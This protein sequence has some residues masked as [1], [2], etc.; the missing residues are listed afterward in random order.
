MNNSLVSVV[1]CTYNGSRFVREQLDSICRQTYTNLEI[2]IMDDASVDGT[3]NIL[4]QIT[5]T[6]K[7][8]KLFRNEQ[9]AGFTENFNRGVSNCNGDYIAFADQDDLWHIEKISRMMRHWPDRSLLIYCNSERFSGIDLPWDVK[10][11]SYY[12]RFEGTDA[13]KLA[14]FNTISGHALIIKKELVPLVFPVTKRV[15]YDWYAGVVAACNGGVSF[16]SDTLVLQRVHLDNST[17]DAGFE[18]RENNDNIVFKKMVEYQLGQFVHSP[19]M[20]EDQII[21]I[22]RLSVK[23]SASLAQRF[24]WPLFFFLVSHRRI[25]FWKKRKNWPFLTLV[26]YC[27]RLTKNKKYT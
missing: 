8:I 7:R 26:K 14:I 12:R 20:P 16:L 17:I 10:A 21:F 1:M 11:A 2:I 5:A 18:Y 22:K 13:R 23:W 25:V 19:N 9:N 24:S 15:M 3:W 27:Y 6:D 4:S